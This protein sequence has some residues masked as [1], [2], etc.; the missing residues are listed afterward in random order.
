VLADLQLSFGR[1]LQ[2]LHISMIEPIFFPW[3]YCAVVIAPSWNKEMSDE[4]MRPDP[5]L[6]ASEL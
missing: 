3:Y 4:V 1:S 2:D 6:H 5:V